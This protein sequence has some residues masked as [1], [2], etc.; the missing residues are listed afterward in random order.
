MIVI[1]VGI[2]S[3]EDADVMREIR[4]EV[5]LSPGKGAVTIEEKIAF[6]GIDHIDP[7]GGVV[8]GIPGAREEVA[9]SGG[10]VGEAG[11]GRALNPVVGEGGEVL[12][13]GDLEHSRLAEELPGFITSMGGPA[14]G[15]AIVK[16]KTV[17]TVGVGVDVAEG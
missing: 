5:G 15:V 14:M 1:L 10:G 12:V 11:I 8:D 13:S 2:S 6:V 17:S 9:D 3:P 16:P 4:G 7:A